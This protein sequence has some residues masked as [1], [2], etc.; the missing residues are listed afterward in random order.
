MMLMLMA[1]MVTRRG[2][3]MCMTC[4]LGPESTALESNMHPRRHQVVS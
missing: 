3:L 1:A 2:A 4:T